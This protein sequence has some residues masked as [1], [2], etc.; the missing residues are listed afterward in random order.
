MRGGSVH[1][2]EAG[3]SVGEMLQ[4][5]DSWK[6]RHLATSG[7]EGLKVPEGPIGPAPPSCSLIPL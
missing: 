3:R 4:P 6:V 5:V 2:R 7:V 1:E